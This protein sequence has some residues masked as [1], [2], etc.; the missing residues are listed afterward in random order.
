[1][2]R[3]GK[4]VLLPVLLLLCAVGCTACGN[5]QELKDLNVLTAVGIQNSG[6]NYEL[7]AQVLKADQAVSEGYGDSYRYF[8]GKGED[9]PSAVADIYA[10]GA[11]E[12][13]FA[14]NKLYLLG[15]DAGGLAELQKMIVNGR[16]DIR[17]QSYCVVVRNDLRQFMTA[18]DQYG[19]DC[20]YK[21]LEVLRGTDE[22]PRIN[23][24]LTALHG[25]AKETRLPIVSVYGDEVRISGWLRLTA[26]DL[27][28][29]MD[30]EQTGAKNNSRERRNA[31]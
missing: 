2:E 25:K 30:T 29:I 26:E 4:K 21:L 19:F 10:Q 17:P 14:H 18:S 31:G 6:K 23:D 9:F 5:A 22:A 27:A 13:T 11:K 28:T 3:I 24:L 7:C 15:G 1:M 8:R 16:Y 20:C 12:L